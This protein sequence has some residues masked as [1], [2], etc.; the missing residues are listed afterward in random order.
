MQKLLQIFEIRKPVGKW[1]G[2]ILPILPFI[3]FLSLYVGISNKRHEA[4]PNDK[5]MPNVEQ[6]TEAVKYSV[7]PDEFSEEVPLL[8]DTA[9]SMK[10]FLMGFSSS[11]AVSLLLGIL[12]GALPWADSLSNAF[13]K[14]VSFLPPVAL[15]PLI[16]LFLG[17]ETR[18]KV[19]IIFVAT[20]IPLTR[21]LVLRVKQISE[22]QIWN[23]KT[24]GP[25]KLEMLWLIIRRQVEPGFLD[26]IRLN[27]GTAWVYLIVAELIASSA[28]LGY[29]INVASRNM[30]IALIIFYLFVISVIAFL[31]DKSIFLLNRWRNKWYFHGDK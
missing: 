27:L 20:V 25:S 3:L 10:L 22:K 31:M 13:M 12:F 7:T 14:V 15:I 24:L 6:I 29:R 18:A 21:A 17:F 28:G 16:F 11:I 8:V 4:N 26:D 5:L 9:S 30:D 23:A 2:R 19:F 1:A